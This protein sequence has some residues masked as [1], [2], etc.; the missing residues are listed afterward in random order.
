[1]T[2]NYSEHAEAV[3]DAALAE[4]EHGYDLDFLKTRTRSV[5]RPLTVG[6]QKATTVPIRLDP[7]RLAALDA[8]AKHNHETRSDLIRRAIDKEL[9]TV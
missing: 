2:E 6:T 1:M 3:F 5:G 7:A 4:A 9:A 8:R